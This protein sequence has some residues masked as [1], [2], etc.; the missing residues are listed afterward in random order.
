MRAISASPLRRGV[1]REVALQDQ[2]RTRTILLLI[3]ETGAGHRSAAN[4]LCQAVHILA[5]L[6]APNSA[7][8]GGPQ[9][10]TQVID[11][12]A[13]SRTLPLRKLGELYDTAIRYTPWLYGALFHLTNHPHGFKLLNNLLYWAMSRHLSRLVIRTKPDLVVS[14][15]PLLNHVLVRVLAR[16][17]LRVP[18][19]T[20][21]TDLVTPHRGWAAPAVDTCIAPTEE[22]RVF[23][24][25][26]GL[27]AER[28]AVI[29]LPVDLRFYRS[30]AT[31]T[32]VCRRLG[33]D[34][35]LPIVLLGGGGAGAGGLEKLARRIRWARLPLQLVVLTGHNARLRRRLLRLA[36]Q[37]PERANDVPPLRAL[38]FVENM[39][40]LMHAADL[41]VTKAG[42]STICEAVAC[43]LP[44][45]LSG[46]VPGQE[47]GNIGYVCEQG[48]GLWARTPED[49]VG[50]LS[51]CLRPDSPLVERMRANMARLQNPP[52][53]LAIAEVLLKHLEDSARLESSPASPPFPLSFPASP[54]AA[55]GLRP[56][57]P[58]SQASRRPLASAR[59]PVPRR[60]DATH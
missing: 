20:V 50:V 31:R 44:L 35:D 25:D 17:D 57:G 14:M 27:S 48:I 7:E 59:P 5:P 4:A 29:G 16:L 24:R 11:A 39:S 38:G 19:V 47:E 36:E 40:E 43:R 52:A 54:A 45:V 12:F 30:A 2:V 8:A 1:S 18:V 34:Q 51:D 28:V 10:S 55:S 26:Q 56:A 37:L 13:L 21:M 9:Y 32:Q 6:R 46:C 33:L 58:R 49:L 60:A 23:C 22:A 41:L 42:P 15:H 53:A 3:A